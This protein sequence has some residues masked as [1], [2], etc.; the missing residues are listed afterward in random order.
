MCDPVRL[1]NS[2]VSARRRGSSLL[3]SVVLSWT[4]KGTWLVSSRLT[5]WSGESW[6]NGGTRATQERD[7]Q[8]GRP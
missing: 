8:G 3:L 6:R 2:S 1:G 4:R 5:G 7:Q